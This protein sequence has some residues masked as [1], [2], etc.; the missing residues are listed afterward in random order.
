[1][2]LL[3]FPIGAKPT[4]PNYIRGQTWPVKRTPKF[5]TIK[6]FTPSGAR[7]A[8]SLYPKIPLWTWEFTCEVILNDPG[9]LNTSVYTPTVPPTDYA[10]LEA[11]FHAQLGAGKEFVYQ[12]PDSVV[13]GSASITSVQVASNVVTITANNS[14]VPGWYVEFNGLTGASFL[15]GQGLRIATATPTQFTCPFTH[16]NYGPTADSGTAQA[17]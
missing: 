17:G 15:H 3:V 11:F 16:A 8:V 4:Q 12:P 2:P 7:A 14:F 9:R 13:G 5:S 6:H 10:I 1:M